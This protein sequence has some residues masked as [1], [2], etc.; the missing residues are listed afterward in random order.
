MK[1]LYPSDMTEAQFEN[2][3]AHLG[4][5]NVQ[6]VKSLYA[7]SAY[8][9]PA[10]LG[11]FSQWWWT[12]MRVATDNGIPMSG[13]PTGPALG[14]CSARR[15][16]EQLLTGGTQSVYMY[17]FEKEVKDGLAF[18]GMEVPFVFHMRPVLGL[19]LGKQ[20][21]S[22][23]MVNYWARF[24]TTGSPNLHS[25]ARQLPHWP[26]YGSDKANIRFDA[27]F[28]SAD[29]SIENNLREAACDFWDMLAAKKMQGL[30]TVIV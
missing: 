15:I 17:H 13:W 8:A 21:L 1:K 5:D 18:H 7:P 27:S 9:Y 14:H 25:A 11:D 23:D 2:L 4:K 22:N 19:S 3:I 20:K 28:L 10:D 16:A 30:Q 24:A 6:K 26:T 29:I 12:A